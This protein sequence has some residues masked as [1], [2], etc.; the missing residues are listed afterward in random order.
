VFGCVQNLVLARGVSDL[1]HRL[2]TGFFDEVVVGA[3][4][5]GAE[6]A[7]VDAGLLLVEAG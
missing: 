6:V 4:V 7:V 5:Q 1:L 2:Q 3:D